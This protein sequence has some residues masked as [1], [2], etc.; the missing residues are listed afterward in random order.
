MG[1]KFYDELSHLQPF[2][3]VKLEQDYSRSQDPNSIWVKLTVLNRTVVLGHPERTVV[4]A[5]AQVMD[6][7]PGL[8][9]RGYIYIY[10]Y[11][12]FITYGG[13]DALCG[14]QYL[15]SGSRSIYPPCMKKS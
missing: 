8:I 4:V 10:I 14:L 12:I 11:I 6:G 7:F 5:L 1:I 2:Q 3:A 9:V 13:I 15:Y